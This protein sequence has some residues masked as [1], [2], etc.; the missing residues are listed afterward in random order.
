MIADDQF[1]IVE[2][3]DENRKAENAKQ[4]RNLGREGRGM[5]KGSGGIIVR[6][7][8]SDFEEFFF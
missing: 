4:K 5:E 1:A 8:C 2:K 3:N 7:V 6:F